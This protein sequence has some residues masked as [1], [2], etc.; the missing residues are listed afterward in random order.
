MIHWS[1]HI[2]KPYVESVVPGT[3][4]FTPREVFRHL[5]SLVVHSAPMERVSNLLVS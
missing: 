1:N 2:P 3:A 5:N 4:I